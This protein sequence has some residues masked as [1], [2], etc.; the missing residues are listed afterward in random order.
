[1][2]TNKSKRYCF[3]D[4]Y[5]L[6]S[7]WMHWL[8]SHLIYLNLT[9][10]SNSQC[11]NVFIQV[12]N[13]CFLDT[14]HLVLLHILFVLKVKLGTFCQFTVV[15]F[16][17]ISNI[18]LCCYASRALRMKL[19]TWSRV[20]SLPGLFGSGWARAQ[21]C[22]HISGQFPACLQNFF[23]TLRATTYCFRDVDL[24]SDLELALWSR[25]ACFTALNSP[26]FT[27]H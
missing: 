8:A 12:R 4:S 14:S 10:L 24:R 20:I 23:I 11:S 22:Q 17:L 27:Q 21:V 25:I 19:L 15:H 7:C 18:I 2:V 3:L 16:D 13:I 26:P 1:M 9:K 6:C 5:T